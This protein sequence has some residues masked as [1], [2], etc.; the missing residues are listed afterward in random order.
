VKLIET[1]R[2]PERGVTDLDGSRPSPNRL[3]GPSVRGRRAQAR[4]ALAP[5]VVAIEYDLNGILGVLR[6]GGIIAG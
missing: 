4:S 2:T 1:L 6:I 3:G 5:A